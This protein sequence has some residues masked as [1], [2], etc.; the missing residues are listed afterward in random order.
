MSWADRFEYA[1]S[2]D[3]SRN[4][5]LWD[6]SPAAP[7]DDKFRSINLL[8][9]SFD[10]AAM[11]ERAFVIVEAIREAIGPFRTVFGVKLLQDRLAWELYF[12]DYLRRERSVSMSKVLSAIRPFV[13]CD[14]VPVESLPYFMFSLDLDE[15]IAC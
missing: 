15:E 14:V 6:Y 5:C 13:R 8:F 4:Y 9:Q 2:Q 10:V 3:P 12:Y 7:A 1:T 11:D